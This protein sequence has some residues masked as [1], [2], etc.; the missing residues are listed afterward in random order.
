M[1]ILLDQLHGLAV[2]VVMPGIFFILPHFF[3]DTRSRICSAVVLAALPRKLNLHI[4]HRGMPIRR[5]IRKPFF[6]VRHLH[7]I[8]ARVGGRSIGFF[9]NRAA[10]FQP[11]L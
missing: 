8:A 10:F 1:H 2:F 4:F 7:T 9:V 11:L 3:G 6:V 5:E